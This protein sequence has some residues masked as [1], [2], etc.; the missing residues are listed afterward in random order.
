[1]VRDE[2]CSTHTSPR[3]PWGTTP[4]LRCQALSMPAASLCSTGI[5]AVLSRHSATMMYAPQPRMG[6]CL[7]V[8]TWWPRPRMRRVAHRHKGSSDTREKSLHIPLWQVGQVALG[9][10]A[11]GAAVFVQSRL[12]RSARPEK[13]L[14]MDFSGGGGVEKSRK[15]P[16]KGCQLATTCLTFCGNL[17]NFLWE[18]AMLSPRRP[19]VSRGN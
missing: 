18:L 4:S 19:A 3:A 9:R 12:L 8:S 5:G 14:I 7:S 13:P 2:E 16:K 17:P 6:A 11:V 15:I 10:R 1:M